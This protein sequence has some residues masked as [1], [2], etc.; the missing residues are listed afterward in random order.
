MKPNSFFRS[1]ICLAGFSL[2]AASAGADPVITF[3]D[4]FGPTSSVNQIG[5]GY[6]GL[7]W[8][9]LGVLDGVDFEFNPSGYQAGVV[10]PKNVAYPLLGN[11]FTR[12]GSMT[13]GMFDLIS[14][15]MTATLN[16]NLNVQVEGFIKGTMVY[17]NTYFL[18][19]TTPAL[20]HFNYFGVDEVDFSATGGSPHP[21]YGLGIDTG[22]AMDNATVNVYSPYS[23][24]VQ[25]GGFES[26][27]FTNWSLLGNSNGC[28][29]TTNALYIHS[30]SSGAQLGPI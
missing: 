27:S 21:G 15:D 11:I 1:I 14:A 9:G 24:G 28:N 8:G 13:G 10:S 4:L 25:N 3:D 17:S 2:I 12:T 26:G 16:D 30:G 29:V 7:A 5:A 20:I 18:S 6:H 23:A 19:A 22:F